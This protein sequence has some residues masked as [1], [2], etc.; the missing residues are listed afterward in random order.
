VNDDPEVRA[1]AEGYLRQALQA[2]GQAI[3]EVRARRFFDLY[4]RD[5]GFASQDMALVVGPGFD[6]VRCVLGY[7]AQPG[8]ATSWRDVALDR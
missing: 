3:V 5:L 6:P 8:C 4:R 2:R 1:Q 7:R